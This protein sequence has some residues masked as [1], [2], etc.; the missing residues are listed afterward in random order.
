MGTYNNSS[1]TQTGHVYLYGYVIPVN[2]SQ[3][4]TSIVFPTNSKVKV[5]AIDLVDQPPQVNLG[6]GAGYSSPAN[7]SALTFNSGASWDGT[8]LD[9]SGDTYSATALASLAG[10]ATSIT[11][12]SQVFDLGPVYTGDAIDGSSNLTFPLPEG[13]Y[14]SI[15]VLGTATGGSAV[16]GTLTVNYVTGGRIPRRSASATGSPASRHRA[17]RLSP[18]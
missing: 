2:S 17:S 10:S 7:I 11:W 15:Q 13:Y 9:G 14:T 16:S 6:N 5:L 12:N 3:A 1:G 18:P 4:I 8:G